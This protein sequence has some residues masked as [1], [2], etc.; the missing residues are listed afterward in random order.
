MCA[1]RA[2]KNSYVIST[3]GTAVF[4]VAERRNLSSTPESP[5]LK[6]LRLLGDQTGDSLSGPQLAIEQQSQRWKR[7]S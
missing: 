7:R 3:G 4:A 6:R 1:F 5:D 2:S